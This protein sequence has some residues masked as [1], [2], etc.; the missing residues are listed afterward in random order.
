MATSILSSISKKTSRFTVSKSYFHK[1]TTRL[2]WQQMEA[3]AMGIP[4]P[5]SKIGLVPQEHRVLV[6][7]LCAKKVIDTEKSAEQIISPPLLPFTIEED[8]SKLFKASW[9]Y[10]DHVVLLCCS[11]FHLHGT[12]NLLMNSIYGPFMNRNQFEQKFRHSFPALSYD[13][14]LVDFRENKSLCEDFLERINIDPHSLVSKFIDEKNEMGN[15]GLK[16]DVTDN[17]NN[18]RIIDLYGIYHLGLSCVYE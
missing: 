11:S 17:W 8:Y 3:I 12:S 2:D 6:P 18:L 7:Q 10:D 13:K 9:S 5:K 16:K 14:F 1:S 4:F 15:L